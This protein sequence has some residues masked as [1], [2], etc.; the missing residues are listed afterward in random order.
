M[1]INCLLFIISLFIFRQYAICPVFIA[2]RY[3][4]F[5][6]FLTSAES[7]MEVRHDHCSQ[8]YCKHQRKALKGTL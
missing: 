1:V 7:S 3:M 6:C 8:I 5:V 2:D 4:F